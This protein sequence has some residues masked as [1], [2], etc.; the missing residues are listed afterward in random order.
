MIEDNKKAL[1]ELKND[2]ADSLV[3]QSQLE[4]QKNRIDEILEQLKDLQDQQN[5]NLSKCVTWPKLEDSFKRDFLQE[6]TDTHNYEH[7]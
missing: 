6:A 2:F 7:L 1:E 4:D 5:E 3:D